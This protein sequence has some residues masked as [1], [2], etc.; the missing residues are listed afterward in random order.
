MKQIRVKFLPLLIVF[1]SIPISNALAAIPNGA[2]LEVSANKR[3]L[4]YVDSRGKSTPF[5][6]FGDD[7]LFNS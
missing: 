5:F 1:L 2:K 4:E 3:F 6:W 7:P